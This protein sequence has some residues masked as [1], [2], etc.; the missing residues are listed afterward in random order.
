MEGL[1][2]LTKKTT[3]SNYHYICEKN[4]GSLSD[5]M[6]ELACFAPGMLAL[7]ASGYGLEKSEQIMNLE[8]ELARACYNFYQTTPTKLSGENYFSHAGQVV[9]QPAFFLLPHRCSL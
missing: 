6:D 4:G 7:G 5:K 9:W 8:K 1:I 3:P 2:S